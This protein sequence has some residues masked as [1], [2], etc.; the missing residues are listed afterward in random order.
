MHFGKRTKNGLG[1]D[2][3]GKFFTFRELVTQVLI[4]MTQERDDPTLFSVIPR[5]VELSCPHCLNVG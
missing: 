3:M 1:S 2:F 4:S 5:N